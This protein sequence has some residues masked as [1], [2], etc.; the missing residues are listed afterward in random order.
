MGAW[1]LRAGFAVRIIYKTRKKKKENRKKLLAES[2][3]FLS[4]QL[5]SNLRSK[6]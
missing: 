3:T 4:R 5:V 1:R 2:L 6:S